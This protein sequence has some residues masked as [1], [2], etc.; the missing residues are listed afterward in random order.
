Q[1]H[2]SLLRLLS[3]APAQA[4]HQRQDARDLRPDGQRHRPLPPR[5]HRRCRRHGDPVR[6]ASPDLVR[7]RV[8]DCRPRD[9]DVTT[10]DI[11]ALLRR[12]R[13][14]LLDFDGPVCSIFAGYP[15]PDVADE[16]AATAAAAGHP[17]PTDYRRNQDPLDVLRF[18][19]TIGPELTAL[20]ERELTNAEV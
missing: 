7:P 9:Q 16:L 8:G 10:S 14:V 5:R 11:E 12:V 18:A 4:D 2:R 3:D 17:V 13:T 1:R 19:G 15:A 6:A 20:I